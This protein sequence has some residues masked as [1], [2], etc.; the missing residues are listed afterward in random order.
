MT[1]TLACRRRRLLNEA[2]RMQW[3]KY[4]APTTLLKALADSVEWRLRKELA[5]L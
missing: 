4:N 5:R 1:R 3:H 2:R